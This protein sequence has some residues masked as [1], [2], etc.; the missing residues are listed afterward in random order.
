M[1]F[2]YTGSSAASGVKIYIDGVS[3]TLT[4]DLDTLSATIINGNANIGIGA[5]TNDSTF[6]N[7]SIDEVRIYNTAVSESI[8]STS[9]IAASTNP[10][11]LH[12]STDTVIKTEGT[13]AQKIQTGQLPIDAA[14]VGYWTLD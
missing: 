5:Y 9:Y 1:A 2:T 7:G 11:T 6:F 4:C 14:T 12:P 3:Q 13:A 8:I 10:D